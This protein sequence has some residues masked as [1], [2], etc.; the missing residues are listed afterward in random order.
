MII[1]VNDKGQITNIDDNV[2]VANSTYGDAVIQVRLEGAP[3]ETVNSVTLAS[4]SVIRA[5]GLAINDLYMSVKQES[6]VGVYTSTLTA[7]SG[8]LEVAGS[9]QISVQLKLSTGKIFST[10]TCTSFVQQNIGMLSKTEANDVETRIYDKYIEPL[11]EN[12]GDKVD[13]LDANSTYD[14][15]YV[16]PSLKDDT[17]NSASRKV[18]KDGEALPHGILGT[19][20]DGKY[21][22]PRGADDDSPAK[23]G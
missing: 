10:I 6:G 21:H 20:K 9:I 23:G 22:I 2:L 17:D 16:Q 7:A 13:K 1:T 11:T 15:L 12:L 3:K 18:L 5:D 14:L 8:V 19:D 4:L